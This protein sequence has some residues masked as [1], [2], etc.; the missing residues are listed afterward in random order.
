MSCCPIMTLNA[1]FFRLTMSRLLFR[2]IKLLLTMAYV[3]Y[4]DRNVIYMFRR[5]VKKHPDKTM[6]IN[7]YNDEEW[8]Y[9]EVSIHDDIENECKQSFKVLIL[10]V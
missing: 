4:T 1:L 8:T 9:Q 7:A 10:C 6:F 5:M 2:G 3:K